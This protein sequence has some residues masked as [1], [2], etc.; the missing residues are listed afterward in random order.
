MFDSDIEIDEG[1]NRQGVARNKQPQTESHRTGF[2]TSGMDKEHVI[3]EEYMTDELDSGA[4]DSCDERPPVIRFNEE[5]AITKDFK[6]KLGMEFSSLN[7]FKK[8]VM[9]HNVLIG[10]EVAFAKNDANRC[11]VVCKEKKLCD[12]TVLC[13][14]VLR[15]TTFKIKTLFP[16]H[17]CGRQFFNKN[18]KAEWVAKVIVDRLRHN[19]K[20]RLT[21]VVADV[22]TRF[23]TEITGSRA[24]KA[25]QL[26]R[27]VVEGDAS[28]QYSMLWS[29]GA[30]LK[31]ASIGNTFKLN[32]HTPGPGLQPRFEKCY[33]CLD[34]TKKAVTQSCRPF[35]G[36][37]G[38]HLKNKYGGILLVAVG[39]DPNDQYLPLAFGVVETESKE[40][41]SW[42]M[43]L[44]IED[45]GDKRWCFMSDQQKGLVQV[46]E[47]EYPAYEHRFCLRHLYANFK[48]KFGGGTLYRDLM[49]AAAKATYFEAHDAKMM[50]IKEANPE[51]FEW[52]NAIP[53]HKWCKHAFPLYSKCDVLMNNLSE[54]FNATILMQRDKPIITMFEWIRN[55]LMGRFATLREKVENY[56]F[57]M[58]SKPLRR[59]DREI[60]KSASWLPTYAGQLKFQVTH[61]QFTD[62]FVVDLGKKS[63]SCNFWDLVGI[64]CRHAVAAIHKKVDDP[65]KYVSECYL[66][67]TYLSCYNEVV[68]PINGQNKWPKT[69]A[70]E[71]LPPLYKRGPGRP[72]KLRRR[73][74]DESTQGRWK[75]TNTSHR[76]KICHVYGHNARTC[77]QG[78][79]VV[80]V[81]GEGARTVERTTQA[82]QSAPV[83]S[84][85][86]KRVTNCNLYTNYVPT[87]VQNDGGQAE[88]GQAASVQND[89]GLLQLQEKH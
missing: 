16:K 89:G 50:E 62:S 21:E 37:D 77:K 88:N 55:Y 29:Y 60:E 12:Y 25:R 11:R 65:I 54:S 20:M 87:S 4:D 26:A 28:K 3:E 49:M 72:K 17:K 38:C 83:V 86:K 39:R 14:R 47:E 42:F 68:T 24:F 13:S 51:A 70:P 85:P 34:G 30:E 5:D 7:Q 76:C 9:E 61:V 59:L 58:M 8:A 82:S 2:I 67:S 15:S 23:S 45:I 69:D 64:P 22:R 32:I 44:L 1:I 66:R 79:Q 31:R 52:V 57:E 33:M 27:Q 35:I 75:R 6:F 81:P 36:L 53:K 18:A 56:K 48:K 78:K 40:T 63:C 73:E 74:V 10:R 43:K 19:S 80:V 46:F 41:W 84:G 71:I